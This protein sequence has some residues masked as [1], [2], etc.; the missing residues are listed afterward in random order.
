MDILS[1]NL[2]NINLDDTNYER[3]EPDTIIL[4]RLL[5][6]HIE[7]EKCKELKKNDK[8]RIHASSVASQ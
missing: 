1:V 3:N 4:T 6:W 2:N 5:A 8:W 7:F